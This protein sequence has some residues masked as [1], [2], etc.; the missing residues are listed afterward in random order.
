MHTASILPILK[1]SLALRFI[2]PK[3]RVETSRPRPIGP[4]SRGVDHGKLGEGVVKGD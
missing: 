2:R 1:H 3:S 4:G